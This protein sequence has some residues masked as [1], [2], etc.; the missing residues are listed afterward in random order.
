[1]KTV[2]GQLF[3][4]CGAALYRIDADG[5]F[6]DL[7]EIVDGLT[8]MAGNNGL[9]TVCVGGRYWVWDGATLS[10]PA[11]GAFSDF[12]AL[13]F[14]GNYTVLT[15]RNGRRFQWS[16]IA[17]AENLPGLNFSEADG[18][19]DNL[20]R[21]FV[22]GG[23]LYLWKEAS[24]EIWYLTGGAGAEAFERAAGGVRDVG[25]KLHGLITG[26]P[27]GA[28]MVGDDNR[29]YIVSGAMQPISTPAVEE[30]ISGGDPT[31]CVTYE[32]EGHTFCA[33][34][35]R[36]RPAWV[37]DM[38]TG[39]WHER[40][41]GLS[42]SPWSVSASVKW[43]GA[44]YAGR[45]DGRVFVFGGNT[46][47]GVPI[48]KEAVTQTLKGD[49]RVIIRAVEIFTRKGITAGGITLSM[50]RDNGVT[51]GAEKVRDVGPIGNTEK[52]V[53]WRNLGQFRQATARIRWD[54]D[55]SVRS[56]GMVMT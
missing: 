38:A 31:D 51:F 6:F 27:G 55:F 18:R 25:L 16:D 52:R 54:G 1:M 47:G 44:W 17:D 23:Q 10:E 9:V 48:T 39:E 12:G 36:D 19:D 32:K 29:A 3:A 5:N 21:P 43:R 11:A 15:E 35:Y 53:I 34:I 28:F 24:H 30:A 33:I 42:E 46:D 22:I 4:A 49:D 8:T 14:F 26:I 45:N 40:S 20:I 37:Y 56:D 41:E 13:E 7:G 2:D 50:S